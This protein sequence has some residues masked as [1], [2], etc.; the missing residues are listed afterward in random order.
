MKWNSVAKPLK[1][2]LVSNGGST[3]GRNSAGR[4]TIFH[5]GGGAKR[6]QRKIDLKRN[7]SAMG[8]VERIEYDPNR[9]SRVALV[10]WIEGVQPKNPRDG[11]K[12]FV[13]PQ[14]TIDPISATVAGHFPLAC[15]ASGIRAANPL[16]KEGSK[17]NSVKD[18]FV[19]AFG[20]QRAKNF[21]SSKLPRIAVSGARPAVFVPQRVEKSV[22]G[23][24]TFCLSDVQRW[25]KDS[26]IWDHRLKNKA[27]VPW[28][29][30]VKEEPLGLAQA[31]YNRETKAAG[32]SSKKKAEMVDRAALT[33]ILASND[34]EPGKMVMNCA[35]PKRS[36]SN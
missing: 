29:S 11:E 8:I 6:L 15:L 23:E 20:S 16:H 10:R 7:T 34:M 22:Q 30:F 36:T 35:L 32:K 1:K 9:S 33:Y 31:A 19:S 28:S 2:L 17:L 21:S 24:N 4:I 25:N 5:R 18:V 26:V 12:G 27:A 14:N 13:T 3:A